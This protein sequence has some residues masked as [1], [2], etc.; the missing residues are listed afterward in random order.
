MPQPLSPEL[1]QRVIDQ[2]APTLEFNI[3]I[4]DPAG[5]IIASTDP[6]RIGSTHAVARAVA[7]GEPGIVHDGA[8]PAERPG[9]NLPLRL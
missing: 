1:A 3:N 7:A 4:M 6:A 8:S 5:R 2:V 9:A